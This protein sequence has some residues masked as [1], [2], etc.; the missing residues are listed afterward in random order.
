MIHM[1]RLITN[2]ILI[3]LLSLLISCGG[4]TGR[5]W[6]IGVSQCSNDDWRSEMNDEVYREML[7]HED[8]DSRYQIFHI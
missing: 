3:V 6:R 5:K 4:D 7:F 2:A 8:A 1:I